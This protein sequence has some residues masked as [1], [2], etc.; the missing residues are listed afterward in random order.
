MLELPHLGHLPEKGELQIL[1][2]GLSGLQRES[3]KEERYQCGQE[4]RSLGPLRFRHEPLRIGDHGMLF[5]NK[6]SSYYSG[7]HREHLATCP[8]ILQFPRDFS[9]SLRFFMASSNSAQTASAPVR[10]SLCPIISSLAASSQTGEVPKFA[11][12]PFSV[13]A[14]CR[15][16]L[17]SPRASDSRISFISCSESSRKIV[18]SS[19]NSSSSPSTR[20]KMAARSTT[21]PAVPKR[22]AEGNSHPLSACSPTAGTNRSMTSKRVLAW[23]G[24]E[25]SPSIQDF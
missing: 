7:N 22:T 10:F 1:R 14:A 9:T 4:E 6:P 20:A 17:L 18:T 16:L 15:S 3:T 24:L 23:T 25:P 19:S 11:A 21:T 2:G 13:W 12:E 5:L 8:L